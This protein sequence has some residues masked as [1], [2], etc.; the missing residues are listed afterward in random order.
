[1]CV[2][3]CLT[4]W[5]GARECPVTLDPGTPLRLVSTEAFQLP[6]SLGLAR[7]RHFSSWYPW[8][9]RG[10]RHISFYYPWDWGGLNHLSSVF[11]ELA[12]T[13]VISAPPALG[14][15]GFKR[16]GTRK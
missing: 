8:D 13:R 2:F 1:M 11:M 6:V 5:L 4:L 10:L 12:R 14:T 9:S 3:F 7:T 16:T 15:E